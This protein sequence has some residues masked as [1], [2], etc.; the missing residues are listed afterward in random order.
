MEATSAEAL[1]HAHLG[2]AI[3]VAC[4]LRMLIHCSV[5]LRARRQPSLLQLR[6]KEEA[7]CTFADRL[8]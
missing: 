7:A 2:K 3:L 8:G 1:N 4:F 5:V 6:R